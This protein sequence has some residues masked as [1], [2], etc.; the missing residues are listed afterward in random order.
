MPQTSPLWQAL[1]LVAAYMERGTAGFAEGPFPASY[2]GLLRSSGATATAALAQHVEGFSGG[3]RTVRPAH[4]SLFEG[5]VTF[6]RPPVLTVVVCGASRPRTVVRDLQEGDLL[7]FFPAQDEP[8]LGLRVV[9][10]WPDS[11]V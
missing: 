5:R 1:R 4:S 6:T 8:S 10:V 3:R 11:Q 7:Y 9:R 2:T